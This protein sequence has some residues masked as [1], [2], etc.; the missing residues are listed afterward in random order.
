MILSKCLLPDFFFIVF[1]YGY[2]LCIPVWLFFND[3]RSSEDAPNEKK[4]QDK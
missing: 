1:V 4:I 3:E 2:L